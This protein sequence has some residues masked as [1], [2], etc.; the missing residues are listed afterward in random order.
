MMVVPDVEEIFVPMQEEL[1]VDPQDSRSH[2]LFVLYLL[3]EFRSRRF[4]PE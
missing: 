4:Y 2:T 1:F 3:I